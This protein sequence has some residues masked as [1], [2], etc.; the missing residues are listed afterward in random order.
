MNGTV[1]ALFA[2]ALALSGCSP[3]DTQ[4]AIY[5]IVLAGGRVMDPESGLDA[6]RNVGVREGIIEAVSEDTLEG[7]RVVDAAG[8]VVAP[9]FIDL[10]VH[11]QTDYSFTFMIRDG[12]TSG[13][14]LEVGTGNVEGWY[15]RRRGGQRANYGVSVGHI[16]IRIAVMNDPSDWLPSGAAKNDPASD[17]QIEVMRRRIREGLDQGAVAVGFGTAYTP[18]ASVAEI[19]T[20]M[21]VAAE[22]GASAHIHV[23]SG[24]DGLAE[25]IDTAER[26]GTALHVVHANSSGGMETPAFLAKIEQ[27]RARGQDVTTEAYPYGA[28]QTRIESALFDDWESWDDERFGIHQW[29]ATGERL[30]RASFARYRK[31]GGAVIIHDRPE[32]MTRAALESPLTMIA[33]DGGIGNGRGHP[34]G[35]GTFSK[36]LGKYVREEGLLSLM[37]ALRRMTIEPARRL[38]TYVLSMKKKGRLQV[39]ADADITLFNPET[40]IDKSTYENAAVPPDGIPY[41]IVNGILVVDKGELVE[42]AHPGKPIRKNWP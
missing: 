40:V 22:V 27:A 26:T 39:G 36:V 1:A 13:L 18:G 11:G 42:G 9:G 20:M 8:L 32:S 3:P 23:R 12:V 24:L 30:T 35:S 34:R 4:D 29:V 7:K 31:Q 17:E 15:R 2:G 5:D 25:A 21:K 10:H 28:G 41:V 16:P 19:E 33:S 37:D 6:I 38:E 14:E